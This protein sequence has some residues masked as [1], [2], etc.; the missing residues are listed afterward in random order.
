MLRGNEGTRDAIDLN[1]NGNDKQAHDK[2]PS[3][4][5]LSPGRVSIALY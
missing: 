3:D 2:E 1:S 5:C 4:K